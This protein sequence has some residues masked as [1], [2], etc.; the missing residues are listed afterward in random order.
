MRDFMADG[1]KKPRQD[2]DNLLKTVIHRFFWDG[3]KLFL[4]ELYEAA[5]RETPAKALDKE[6]AKVTF[7]IED[8]ADRVDMLEEIRLADGSA[9]YVICHLE[10]QGG[11]SGGLPARMM[12]Y[13]DA[14]HLLHKKEPVGIAVITGRRQGRG[15]DFYASELFGVK[16]SYEYQNFFLLDTDDRILLAEDNRVG[17]VLYAAKC[18]HKSGKDEAEK[19]QYLRHISDLWNTR[20]WEP[21]DKRL[22]LLAVDYLLKLSDKGLRKAYAEHLRKLEMKEGDREMYQSMIEEVALEEYIQE[23]TLKIAKNFLS[24]GISPEVISK[25]TGL[26]VEEVK[27][28]LP[29]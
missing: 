28:L 18:T 2:Y 14:I 25:N 21:K 27:T 5:D 8:G 1:V 26:S 20:G 11:S 19:L 15:H 16:V 13:R 4:P 7:D 24:D 29:C 23:N 6:L 12:F 10:L 17:L 9:G 3:L 22:I